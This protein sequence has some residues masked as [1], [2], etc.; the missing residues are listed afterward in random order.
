MAVDFSGVGSFRIE[1]S[2]ILRTLENYFKVSIDDDEWNSELVL[3]TMK[4]HEGI[5]FCM[6]ILTA[7]L[8]AQYSKCLFVDVLL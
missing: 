8:S 2:L 3:S 6:S 5:L 4:S 7:S 1:F